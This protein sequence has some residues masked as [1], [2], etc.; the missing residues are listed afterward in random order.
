MFDK[1]RNDQSDERDADTFARQVRPQLVTYFRK[2]LSNED[3]AEELAQECVL[4]FVS[5]RYD[6]ASADARPIVFGIARHVLSDEIMRLRRDSNCMVPTPEDH[7]L[8]TLASSD[9]TPDRI[10]EGRDELTRVNAIVSNLPDRT[11]AIFLMSRMQGLKHAE[12]AENLGISRS[13]VEKHIMEAVS[14]LLRASKR[15]LR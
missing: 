3:R 10:A 6:P 9:P 5:G 15:S 13:A 2:R 14:R 8:D 1:Y 12:I 7:F 11:R 4:R